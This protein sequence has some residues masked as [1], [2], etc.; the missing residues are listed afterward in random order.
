MRATQRVWQPHCFLCDMTHHALR[1]QPMMAIRTGLT[2][3]PYTLCPFL[4]AAARQVSGVVVLLLSAS[5]TCPAAAAAAHPR[6]SRSGVA[7]SY[8]EF[9]LAPPH[10]IRGSPGQRGSGRAVDDR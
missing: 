6:Y 2:V 10:L 1:G 9:S 8:T 3:V 4:T 5:A 7:S